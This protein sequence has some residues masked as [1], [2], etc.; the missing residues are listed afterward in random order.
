MSFKTDHRY[1]H[2]LSVL[3]ESAKID[4]HYG[5][6]QRGRKNRIEGNMKIPPRTI[7]RHMFTLHGVWSASLVRLVRTPKTS[8]RNTHGEDSSTLLLRTCSQN[9]PRRYPCCGSRFPKIDTRWSHGVETCSFTLK[10]P[11]VA[12]MSLRLRLC[13]LAILLL[14]ARAA[15]K[16][17]LLPQVH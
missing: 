11:Y 10:D 7:K 4:C 1:T 15:Y 6:G 14:L 8:I 13:P 3:F 9:F 2:D 16:R 12:F 5:Y 17:L